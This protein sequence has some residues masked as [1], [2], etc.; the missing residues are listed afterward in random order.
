MLAVREH[1]RIFGL[2]VLTRFLEGEMIMR[3]FDLSH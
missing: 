1:M 3:N 2:Q